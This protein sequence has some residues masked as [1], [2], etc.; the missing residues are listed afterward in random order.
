MAANM[1]ATKYTLSERWSDKG[2][3]VTVESDMLLKAV[4]TSVY[5]WKNRVVARMIRNIS[6][7]L[8]N[9]TDETAINNLL[10]EQMHLD[11]IKKEISA[12]L[13]IVVLK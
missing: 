3:F 5:A 8:K 6:E 2:I 1:L 12:K 4:N 7:Q 9:N 10:T 13:G 11:Q